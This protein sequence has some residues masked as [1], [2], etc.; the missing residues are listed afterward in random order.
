MSDKRTFLVAA[1]ILLVLSCAMF[2]DVIFTSGQTVL[3]RSG[4]DTFS[5]YVFWRDFAFGELRKGNLA[6][7]NPYVYSGISH[8][9]G[10]QAA[11]FYP[12]HLIYLFVPLAKAINVTI[13]FHVFLAGLFMYLWTAYRGLRSEASLF[14][15]ILFMFCGAHFM[16]IAPGH[17][18]NLSAMAWT[19]LIFLS[20]DGLF[21]RRPYGFL[22]LG[23]GAVAMQILAGHPQYV[24][25]TAFA[26][27]IYALLLTVKTKRWIVGLIAFF[28]IYAGAALLSAVQLFPGLEATAETTRS[29]GIPYAFASLFSFPPENFITV[30]APGFFGTMTDMPYWGRW[31]LSETT[32]FFGV[33]GLF[34]AVYGALPGTRSMRRFSLSMICV[35]L[36]LAMG[37][38]TPLFKIFYRWV[39]GFDRFR[40]NAK[41]IFQASLFMI[42]LAG[43]GFDRFV[44]DEKRRHRMALTIAAG[45]SALAIGGLAFFIRH[46]ALTDFMNLWPRFVNAVSTAYI[47][48]LPPELFADSGFVR[49]AGL[50]S[51]RGLGIAAVTCLVL[52][53]VLLLSR[54]SSRGIYLVLFLASFEIFVFARASRPT[55]DLE[56]TRLARMRHFADLYPGDYRVF[57]VYNPN[58]TMSYGLRNITGYAT[59]L[60]LRRYAEFT[61]FTQGKD[62]ESAGEAV[63]FYELHPLFEMLRLKYILS[64]DEDDPG[65]LTVLESRKSPLPR[66]SLLYDWRLIEERDDI[67]EAMGDVSFDP[68]RTVILET[69][70]QPAPVAPSAPGTVRLVDASTDHV[71]IE[72]QLPEPAILLMTDA[73]SSGWRARALAGSVQKRYS[74]LPANYI[75]R[76]IPLAAGH[77]MVRVEYLPLGFLVGKWVSIASL[78]IYMGICGWY[79]RS[80]RAVQRDKDA[81]L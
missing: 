51:S 80:R 35:L 26:A 40:G 29:G 37:S 62:P 44:R 49:M 30:V 41:F 31:H 28:G 5:Q 70:P 23:I 54:S 64:P 68:R 73:Y 17:L 19:P 81:A 69:E 55:F 8:V 65:E 27:C 9:G 4:A 71:T 1:A 48:Y 56:D 11:L 6:L 14:S 57:F 59:P 53:L 52:S 78:I 20:I 43:I 32:L 66:F 75:L 3:S 7:W 16:H 15:S 10:F 2:F 63:D 60:R 18:S 50:F 74:I 24:Y 33:T 38:H 76:A 12:P 39:P 45:I 42:L 47:N 58:M 13:A 22:L 61:A 25:Y 72:A 67:F 79:V 46:A 77:H 36:L 21:D 34:F